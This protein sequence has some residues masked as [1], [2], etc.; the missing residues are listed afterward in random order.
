VTIGGAVSVT[1]GDFNGDGILDL[2]VAD[3][4]SNAIT[5]LK[6]N[7]DGT[8]TQVNG[9]PSLLAPSN[10]VASYDFNGDGKLDLVFSSSS[11]NLSVYLG[12]GDGTFE[13]GFV[14]TM[15]FAPYGIGVGDFNGDG[16]LD[17]AVTNSQDNTVSILLQTPTAPR[18]ASIVLASGQL[19]AY[20]GQPVTYEAVVTANGSAPTGSV[21]FKEGATILGTVPLQD[22][23]AT[24]TTTFAKA[25]EFPI[26]ATYSGDQNHQTRSSNL[27]KQ[28]V[29][30]NPTNANLFAD[31]NPSLHGQTVTFMA[32]I[33]SGGPVP[34]GKVIFKNG[35]VTMGVRDLVGGVATFT[36]S[37]LPRG[38]Y[39]ITAIYEGDAASGAS[40]SQVWTQVVE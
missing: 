23:Q 40:T 10:M 30:K 18:R 13:A 25:G 33:S 39:S 34:T 4:G 31:V 5:V 3:A 32:A 29:N 19:S 26:V 16:R 14:Q 8:F 7:G 17:L 15:D 12:H 38:S 37:N 6:G 21:A 11:N 1:T 28:V 9:Q 27:V 36:K 20:V 35:S 24:F 22:G 2:A